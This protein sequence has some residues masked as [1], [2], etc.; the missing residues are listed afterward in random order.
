MS[1]DA[2]S[3]T[4]DAESSSPFHW[5]RFPIRIVWLCTVLVVLADAAATLIGLFARSHWLADLF[6]NLRVQ[7]VIA[8]LIACAVFTCL[9]KWRWLAVPLVLLAFHLP[10]FSSAFVGKPI[11]VREPEL[12][13]MVANVL[14]SNRSPER[15][16]DQVKQSNADAVAILELGTPLANDLE[17]EIAADYP[18][19]ISRPQD[20]GN[21]GIGLYSR[22]PLSNVAAFT[23]N[24]DS[25]ESISAN[26]ET[27][28]GTYR[29]IA[30]HPLPPV[31]RRGFSRRNE[32]LEMLA[33]RLGEMRQREPDV[34]T[35]VVG[36]LNL[37]P[38]SPLMD[39]F[40]SATK[41]RRAGRGYGLRPTWYARMSVFPMGLVLDHGFI[42]SDLECV[43]RHVGK[44]MGSDHRAVTLGIAHKN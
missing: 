39:D 5:L 6:T 22:H 23:L 4:I 27:G 29:I 18:H 30:T 14:T 1:T 8:L 3:A 40:E 2:S 16:I 33:Q 15:V 10:W 19:R 42:S 24:V 11:E 7:Q 38:W 21:F 17:R 41:L 35:I 9:R 36:D 43:S 13:V 25:I 31:G 34:P 44:P 20:L 28:D 12:V 26:V 32:H 37:T